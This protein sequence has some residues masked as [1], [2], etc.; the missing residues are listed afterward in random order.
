[1]HV[2]KFDRWPYM[3]IHNEDTDPRLRQSTASISQAAMM[4]PYRLPEASL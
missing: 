3:K 1:M 4:Y 2:K